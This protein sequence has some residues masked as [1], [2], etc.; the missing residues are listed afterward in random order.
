MAQYV[1]EIRATSDH[2]ESLFFDITQCFPRLVVLHIDSGSKPSNRCTRS[3]A[4]GLASKQKT[5]KCTVGSP[6]TDSAKTRFAKA[7]ERIPFFYQ[8]EQ[9]FGMDGLLPTRAVGVLER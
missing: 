9:V 5:A 7:P 2:C 1:C 6:Q 4:E 8:S 3:V